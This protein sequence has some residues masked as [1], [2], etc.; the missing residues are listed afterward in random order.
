MKAAYY[1]RFGSVDVL[2]VGDLP[3]PRPGSGEVAV[4]VAA[5]AL[6]PKDV[7]VRKCIDD[8]D[9]RISRSARNDL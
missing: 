5:A 1:D 4:R 2:N 8:L 3:A 6:N 9:R 7:L